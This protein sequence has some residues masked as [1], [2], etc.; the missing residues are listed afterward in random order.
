MLEVNVRLDS[1]KSLALQQAKHTVVVGLLLG[2]LLS[3]AQISFDFI[4]ERGRINST[5]SEV[6]G[7][8]R[9]QAAQA[10]Y[11]MNKSLGLT[12][13]NGLFEYRPIRR[14]ALVDDFGTTLAYRERPGTSGRMDWLVRRIFGQDIDT[15]VPL[16]LADGKTPLGQIEI[17]LDSYL[18]G[19][20]FFDRSATLVFGNVCLSVLLASILALIT[21]YS[22]TKPLLTV[23]RG[24]SSVDTARP[25]EKRLGGLRGH[26]EDEMGLLVAAVNRL[27]EGFDESLSRYRTLVETMNDGLGV[28]DTGGRLIYVNDRLCRMLG[29]AREDTKERLV[30]DFMTEESRRGFTDL[31]DSIGTSQDRAFEVEWLHVSGSIVTTI[32]APRAILDKNGEHVETFAVVHDI[33]DR[34]LAERALRES[35]ARFKSAFENAASGMALVARDGRFLQVNQALCDIMGCTED[36]LLQKTW[37]DIRHPADA[38]NGE[39]GFLEP[40]AGFAPHPFEKRYVGKDGGDVWV[41]ESSSLVRNDAGAPAYFICHFLD[42]SKKKLAEQETR[43]L[44]EQLLQSQKM[45]AV[46]RL[47]GGVAHDFNNMLSIIQGYTDMAF[48]QVDPAL[49]L[50]A[51]LQEIRKAAVR[52]ANLTRQLLAFA[53]RQTAIPKVLNLN[54]TVEGM[55]KM[56]RR[57]IGEDIDLAWQPGAGLWQIKID[58]SQIDQILAN[59][60]VN[61]RDAIS[62]VGKVTI[63]TRNATIDRDY[64]ET[65]TGFVPG[66]YVLLSVSDNGHG[67]DKETLGRLFEPFF[68]TKGIG[69]GTGLGLATVYGIVRQ[70]NGLINVYSEPGRGTAFTIYI[71][72]HGDQAIEDKTA[73]PT[74][75]PLGRGETALLVE[76]EP[77]ILAMTTKMLES[78]GYKVLSSSSPKEALSLAE[79][80]TGEIQLL[81]T[82]VIMPEM[83]GQDL[84]KALLSLRPNAKVLFMSGYTADV[85]ASH[86]VLEE[87]VHFIQKPF[88]SAELVGKVRETLDELP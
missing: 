43:K 81:I 25:A 49:P 10:A 26:E 13:V 80:H 33:T 9:E 75:T 6:V 35:E 83:N 31:Q 73:P 39:I 8:V 77:A 30:T 3:T 74:E 60:C 64:C 4:K 61:A 82:D 19:V 23:S 20:N 42:I 1:R 40:E 48:D 55:L 57:L 47:A 28:F 7:M 59:L 53:R 87:G 56:L 2:L 41:L 78:R 5:V 58:P 67:M 24:L 88:S 45:E 71:P 14:A 34:T 70:N 32:M 18:I 17:S 52:S 44:Q 51:D 15:A 29:R 50:Y 68:T 37:M 65:H 27:L 86:G 38:P 62:G 69:K 16:F 11:N 46:G 85:I 63:L 54:D 76:D 66:D 84:F 79:S 36:E 22:I 21:Y 12:V 72:R